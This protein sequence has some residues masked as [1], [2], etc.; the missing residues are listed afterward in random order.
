MAVKNLFTRFVGE[1]GKMHSDRPAALAWLVDNLKASNCGWDG[2]FG[3]HAFLGNSGSGRTRMV[4][5]AAAHLQK[6]GRKTLVL[7]VH[8]EHSGEIRR[9][10]NAAA[11]LGFDAAI[12][13]K[14]SQLA[15]SEKHLGNYEAVLLDLPALGHASLAVGGAIHSWLGRN[16]SFHRHLVIPLDRDFQDLEELKA[17]ARTWNCDWLALSRLDQ[18]RL[19]GKILD[20]VES[21]PLPFSLWG[22]TIGTRETLSIADS[23]ALL[24][25]ILAAGSSAG[26]PT[27]V[28]GEIVQQELAE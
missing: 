16:H 10:Q 15:M 22:E 28:S 6:Q 25:R 13:R 7:S 18:T 9:L 14:D 20:L 24:D 5:E 26:E 19:Q 1:T 23:G 12:I 27:F 4:L 21:I 17:A 2:F 8:P 11:E 3:C